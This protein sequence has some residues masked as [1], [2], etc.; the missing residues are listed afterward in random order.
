MPDVTG[1]R[2]KIGVIVPSTNTVVEHD[3]NKLAPH[4]IT[5]HC[6][7]MY[8]EQQAMGDHTSFMEL[9]T[10]IRGSMSVALRDVMTAQ[11]DLM[12]MGMSAPTFSGGVAGNEAFQTEVS[13]QIGGMPVTT[14]ASACRA[15]L[16]T[17]GVTK[18]SVFSPYQPVAD[19]W[20]DQYFTEAG[21]DVVK[22]TGLRCPTATSIASVTPRDLVTV[23]EEIDTPET[24]AIVQVGTNL[25]FIRMADE[26]ETWLGKPVVAINT[27]TV[28]HTLRQA[29]FTDTVGGYGTIIREF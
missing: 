13:E 12:M 16:E 11:P 15:A 5:F 14:G 2:A 21:F 20:V 19:K 22:V 1:Y 17:L 24:E 9:Q 27:A 28:W 10:Q 4:G 6:G 25:S 18:I 7:R 26:A 3:V 23:L 29:G 8:V